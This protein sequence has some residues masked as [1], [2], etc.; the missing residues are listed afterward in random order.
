MSIDDPAVRPAEHWDVTFAETPPYGFGTSWTLHVGRSFPDVPVP[1]PFY[2]YVEALFHAGVTSG[3]GAGYCP[4]ASMTRA[5][6]AVFLLKGKFGSGYVPP[7]A[8]GTVFDD[9]PADSFAA[10]WIEDLYNQGIADACQSHP[11][12]YCPAQ[13]VTRSEMAVSLLKAK[14][15]SDHVPPPCV[16]QFPDVP[17]E[18]SPAY[19][20]DWIEEL[21]ALGITGGC[22]GG[23]FCPDAL[24]TR[25]QMA[26]FI[27]K[28]FGLTF[29]G[30]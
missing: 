10:D 26:V 12:M 9:V 16:G 4:D 14:L 24:N 11:L 2:A 22:G 3:C 19:P 7:P 21:Y 1:H 30:L 18:P 20:V 28:T 6:M 27:T 23:N 8:T 29:T 25:G 13:A 5:Q 15:G 17:C